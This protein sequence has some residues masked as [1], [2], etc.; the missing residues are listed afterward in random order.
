[1]AIFYYFENQFLSSITGVSYIGKPKSNTMM[2]LTKKIESKLSLLSDVHD[3]L[4]FIEDTV[5]VPEEI[6]TKHIFIK[7]INPASSYTEIA[8]LLDAKIDKEMR[9]KKYTLDTGGFTTGE[10]VQI[11]KGTIIEPFVF[12]DHGVIIGKNVLIKTGA[13]IRC[14]TIIGDDCVIGENT[15]IGEPAFNITELEDGRVV[16]IPS[17]GGVIIGKNVFIGANCSISKG[18]ADNTIIDDNV[19]IDSNVRLGHDVYLHCGAEIIACSAIG[20]Y[21][22]I[23][24]RTVTSINCTLKNRI[25]VGKNCFV[26]MG[27]VVNRDIKDNMEIS[28]N[29]AITL[30]KAAKKRLEEA[31]LRKLLRNSNT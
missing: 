2:Y 10:N 12:L 18:G 20:G 13:K 21:C 31:E 7:C 19:K 1:M 28:G 9:V 15:V 29:P 30:E 5:T 3:C 16:S 6:V 24:E 4:V 14:N 8:L 22:E 27:S 26:G 11:G 23:G 17:F 25:K